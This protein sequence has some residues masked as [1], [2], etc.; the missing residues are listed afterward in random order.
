M[1]RLYD[2][3]AHIVVGAIWFLDAHSPSFRRR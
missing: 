2:L 3:I 1:N